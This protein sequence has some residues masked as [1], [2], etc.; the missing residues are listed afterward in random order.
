MHK[1]ISTYVN[2]GCF[3]GSCC[4]NKKFGKFFARF[5]PPNHLWS[6]RFW[7]LAIPSVP[8]NDI[9]CG[10]ATVFKGIEGS[11]WLVINLLNHTCGCLT[12]EIPSLNC[13]FQRPVSATNRAQGSFCLAVAKPDCCRA[14]PGMVNNDG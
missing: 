9:N 11:F 2:S 14:C 8:S 1:H 7:S 12:H 4:S 6:A 13:H 3:R 10:S 5:R